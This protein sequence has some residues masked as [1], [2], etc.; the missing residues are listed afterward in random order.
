M[1][2]TNIIIP[3]TVSY[4]LEPIFLSKVEISITISIFSSKIRT[5]ISPYVFLAS[6]LSYILVW[7]N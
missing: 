4:I 1:F 6:T 2:L 7:I 5:L 3:I